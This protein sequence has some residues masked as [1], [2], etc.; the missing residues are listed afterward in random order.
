MNESCYSHVPSSVSGHS[1][2]KKRPNTVIVEGGNEHRGGT[3]SS[4]DVSPSPF[5]QVVIYVVNVTVLA[6]RNHK[7]CKRCFC[8]QNKAI[9]DCPNFFCRN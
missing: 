6:N 7:R 5:I 4:K 3:A 2:S 9:P 8:N 1:K